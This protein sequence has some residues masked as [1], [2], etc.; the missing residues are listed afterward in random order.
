MAADLGYWQGQGWNTT[1]QSVTTTVTPT[2]AQTNTTV[3]PTTTA[4]QTFAK[5]LEDIYDR[6]EKAGD[7]DGLA[8]PQKQLAVV[9]EAG[10]TAVTAEDKALAEQ[11]LAK[12]KELADP[13]YKSMV[14]VALDEL[15][16]TL[17][18]SEADLTYKKNQI[19]TKIA[20]LNQD[21]TYNKE[22]LTLD[23]QAEMAQQ[24]A[25]YQA[26]KESNDLAMQEA[27]LTFS[28]PRQMAEQ[29]LQAS[30]DLVAQSTARKYAASRR[31]QEL[32]VQRNAEE[33]LKEKELA[34]R[35]TTEAKTAA[36]RT[37][38]SKVGSA[39][40]PANVNGLGG[41]SGSIED[42]R[43]SAILELSDIIAQ[44]KGEI[45]TY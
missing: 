13:Y 22:K 40:L 23:E 41:V 29:K 38:E 17:A 16:R 7:L 15:N 25:E 35:Q 6:M 2:P 14:N 3:A 21:L 18:T 42:A 30:T 44:R 8:D 34:E 37:T 33:L 36:T 19:D 10:L 39:A 27:G 5:K 11:Y 32:T 12:A 20:E 45:P 31:E 43:Q 28:S 24:L 1:K 4:S 9:Q 26:A